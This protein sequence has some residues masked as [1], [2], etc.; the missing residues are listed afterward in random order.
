ML[1]CESKFAFRQQIV[2]SVNDLAFTS[3][4]HLAL[5]SVNFSVIEA[6]HPQPVLDS[7]LH[8]I[9]RNISVDVFCMSA[10]TSSRG[11]STPTHRHTEGIWAARQLKVI[12]ARSICTGETQMTVNNTILMT[13]AVAT[14]LSIHH[15]P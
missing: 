2:C 13:E 10:S 11:Q 1:Y 5:L 14:T 12:E 15:V 4:S 8:Y 6:N 3:F 9:P 7:Q